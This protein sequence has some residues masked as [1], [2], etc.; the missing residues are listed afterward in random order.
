MFN[1]SENTNQISSWQ[2][3]PK[4]SLIP[5][6]IVYAES[7]R[8]ETLRPEVDEILK[9]VAQ[10]LKESD[11]SEEDWLAWVFVSDE[12]RLADFTHADSDVRKLQASLDLPELRTRDAICD[13]ALALRNRKK[14][15]KYIH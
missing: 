3:Q 15:M 1:S 10:L 4:P 14:A 12:S 6:K 13:I 8:I 5:K 11:E 9:Q 2:S 7:I